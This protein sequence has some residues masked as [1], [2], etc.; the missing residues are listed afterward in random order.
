[1][2]T[3]TQTLELL[4]RL[5]ALKKE[6][7]QCSAVVRRLCPKTLK[8]IETIP[9]DYSQSHV[10]LKGG[11]QYTQNPKPTAK[12]VI[13][14][15]TET[16]EGLKK[17]AAQGP[18]RLNIQPWETLKIGRTNF[19][20]KF[21]GNLRLL[22]NIIKLAD[23]SKIKIDFHKLNLSSIEISNTFKIEDV[24]PEIFA[25]LPPGVVVSAP[26]AL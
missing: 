15:V 14:A 9:Y 24:N 25:K 11:K 16:V 22:K 17:V 23:A 6:T 8:I 12:E 5:D 3:T 26:C 7:H 1:M 19:F 2:T 21:G 18:E 13:K 4:A 10:R 20:R